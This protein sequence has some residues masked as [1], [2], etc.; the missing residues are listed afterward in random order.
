ML[1][2]HW[3][4]PWPDDLHTQTLTV[5]PRDIPTVQIWTSF[6]H[7]LKVIV[8]QTDRQTD[9][10]DKNLKLYT[11]PFH[12]WS[13]TSW[14]LTFWIFVN[15]S[16]WFL[17]DV[18]AEHHNLWCHR[19]HFVAEAVFIDTI[20]VCCK[21]V[22]SIRL[23]LTRVDRFAIWSNNLQQSSMRKL[24]ITMIIKTNRSASYQEDCQSTVSKCQPLSTIN[25][26]TSVHA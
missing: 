5:F 16:L 1:L 12:G 11:M 3:P 14:I 7:L 23:P 25:T 17:A 8:W 19:R 10:R 13:I 9:S 22:F 6:L 2:W 21:R 24:I 15:F 20:H 26:S 18:N 4:W